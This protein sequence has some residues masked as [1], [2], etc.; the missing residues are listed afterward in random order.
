MFNPLPRQVFRPRIRE[1]LQLALMIVHLGID[2]RQSEAKRCAQPF[3][4]R[5]IAPGPI[6]LPRC[7]ASEFRS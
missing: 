5:L 6:H 2:I 3:K 1:P 7:A 4:F